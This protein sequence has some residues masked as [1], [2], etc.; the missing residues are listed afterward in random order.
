M[1]GT[2][3]PTMYHGAMNMRNIVQGFFP[4]QRVTVS[5]YAPLHPCATNE[6]QRPV[7][8]VA[9]A[10]Q[11]CVHSSYHVFVIAQIPFCSSA[12]ELALRV[13][14]APRVITTASTRP[15]RPRSPQSPPKPDA[16][17]VRLGNRHTGMRWHH[18]L[19][20]TPSR[21]KCPISF[22][23]GTTITQAR[24]GRAPLRA[25]TVQ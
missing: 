14:V 18:P 7:K 3:S 16:H 6:P 20:A 2:S 9:N 15:R 17:G 8:N 19:Q 21:Q 24:T 22:H 5:S 12:L 11:R 4:A 25:T 13:L 23:S 1:P 10:R